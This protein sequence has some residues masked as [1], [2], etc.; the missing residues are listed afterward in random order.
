MPFHLHFDAS[1]NDIPAPEV[2]NL[3]PRSTQLNMKFTML[4]SIKILKNSAF[5]GSDKPR[6][7]FFLLINVKMPTIVGI[8]TIINRENFM[9]SRAEHEKC[10]ITSGPGPEI[11]KM[12]ML[13]SIVGI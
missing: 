4:I 11:I 1:S 7:L 10:F 9:L 13:S 5:L 3:F 2:I 6:M 8:L 12:F